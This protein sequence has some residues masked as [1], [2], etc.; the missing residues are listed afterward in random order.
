[1]WRFAGALA[2]LDALALG[3][4]TVLVWGLRGS[5]HEEGRPNGED[6]LSLNAIYVLLAAMVVAHVAVAAWGIAKDR[7]DAWIGSL[8]AVAAMPV[9]MPI[10][11]IVVGGLLRLFY[12]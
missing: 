1:M 4:W 7:R 2:V 12:G 9:T 3:T 5:S 10:G 6:V 8:A 11:V